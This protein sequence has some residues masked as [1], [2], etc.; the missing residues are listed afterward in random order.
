MDTPRQASGEP[1]AEALPPPPKRAEIIPEV[2]HSVLSAFATVL[3]HP[4]DCRN[5]LQDTRMSFALQWNL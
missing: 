5:G 2:F 4:V 1:V 3:S